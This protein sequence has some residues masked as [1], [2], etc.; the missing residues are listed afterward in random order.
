MTGPPWRWPSFSAQ[1]DRFL[2]RLL[3]LSSGDPAGVAEP[4][5]QVVL[6]GVIEEQAQQLSCP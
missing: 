1:G 5:R 2:D 6:L 4:L 3:A